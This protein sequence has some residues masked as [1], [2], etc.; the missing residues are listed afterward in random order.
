MNKVDE[1]D[2]ETRLFQ[3]AGFLLPQESPRR[4]RNPPQDGKLSH[5]KRNQARDFELAEQVGS[6]GSAYPSQ[7]VIHSNNPSTLVVG[8]SSVH[9]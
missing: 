8:V 3:K 1:M 4:V 5:D 9:V 6:K 2:P 7:L